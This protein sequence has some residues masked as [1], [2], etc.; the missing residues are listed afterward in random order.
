[1]GNLE[2]GQAYQEVVRSGPHV[3]I[4]DNDAAHAALIAERL[5]PR[6]LLLTTH[7]EP[8][9]ALEALRCTSTACDIVVVN[10]SDISHPWLA[11][12]RRLIEAC[13]S[14]SQSYTS[15]F[16]C[17]SR[18]KRDSQFQLSIERM[19]VRFVYER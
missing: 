9:D 13:A 17:T 12:L 11:I 18:V 16:L 7:R 10:V 19:G 15:F 4:L 5:R 2:H 1:M 14:R 6:Q 8:E 3:M